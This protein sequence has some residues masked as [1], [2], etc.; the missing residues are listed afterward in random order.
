M[1]TPLASISANNDWDFYLNAQNI[2]QDFVRNT[3]KYFTN[4]ARA[5]FFEPLEFMNL[6]WKQWHYL[7]D[8]V[9][10][11]YSTLQHFEAL[12]LTAE[13]RHVLYGFILKFYEG[14]PIRFIH[15]QTAIQL[16]LIEEV[17]LRY[18]SDTPEKEFC[19]NN[20]QESN[21]QYLSLSASPQTYRY[22]A[23]DFE[24]FSANNDWDYYHRIDTIENQKLWVFTPKKYFTTGARAGFIEPLAFMN[25]LWH[26]HKFFEANIEKPYSV[27]QHFN[28]LPFD[29]ELKHVFFWLYLKLNNSCP[30]DRSVIGRAADDNQRTILGLIEDEFLSYE[31]DTPEKRFFRGF[32]IKSVISQREKDVSNTQPQPPTVEAAHVAQT[33]T[34]KERNIKKKTKELYWKIYNSYHS[35]A[36]PPTRSNAKFDKDAIDLTIEQFKKVEGKKFTPKYIQDAINWV[37][38][39]EKMK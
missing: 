16:I 5:G 1:E 9:E 34:Q 23:K 19:R 37:I 8:N 35:H 18:E 22:N 12:P 10:K 20:R 25:L 21:E 2:Q 27:F 38:K 14:Y 3:R 4:G 33:G 26:Q 6:W 29:D 32:L 28:E 11:P 24:G 39:N 15:V 31:G 36:K 17:F 30:V 13:Q 7:M